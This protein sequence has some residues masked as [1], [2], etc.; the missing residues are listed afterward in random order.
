[1]VAIAVLSVVV[2][3]AI[4]GHQTWLITFGGVLIAWRRSGCSPRS[5]PWRSSPSPSALLE[6]AKGSPPT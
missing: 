5:N 1:M 2:A 6:H 4:P 3:V